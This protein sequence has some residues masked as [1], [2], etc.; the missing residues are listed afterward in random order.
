MKSIFFIMTFFFL[1]ISSA[2]Q[3]DFLVLKRNQHTVKSFFAGNRVNF[4]TGSANYSG[5]INAIKNDSVFVT[6]FDIRQIRTNLG[7]YVLD[8]V[9]RYYVA[10]PY[11]NI[12]GI[13]SERTGFNWTA[14]G[15]SLLGGG[16]LLTV[17]GSGTWIFTKPGTQYNASPQLVIVSAILG[18]VG[19][20]LLRSHGNNYV[21]GKK[22]LLQYVQVK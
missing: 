8:T 7:V 12:T 18:G 16:I 1:S 3:A 20:F 22:Y 2:Q 21:I 11:K 4:L 19:Y 10:F 17:I 9:A 15:A 14:S 6:E 13:T 5:R